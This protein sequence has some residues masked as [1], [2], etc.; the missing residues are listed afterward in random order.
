V[1]ASGFCFSGDERLSTGRSEEGGDEE[2]DAKVLV[3]VCRN[4]SGGAEWRAPGGGDSR[5]AGG[6]SL[7]G[8]GVVNGV[9]SGGTRILL[10]GWLRCESW[11]ELAIGELEFG[12]LAGATG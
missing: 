6:D 10:I 7:E 4:S 5:D 9:P 8:M 1:L 3:S 2:A 11:L 12:E